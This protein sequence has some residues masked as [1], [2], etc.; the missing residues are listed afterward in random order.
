MGR[1]FVCE[2]C[3]DGR[4]IASFRVGPFD[5]DGMFL[6]APCAVEGGHVVPLFQVHALD[7]TID[8]AWA[9]VQKQKRLADSAFEQWRYEPI[10]RPSI[11]L[12]DPADHGIHMLPPI[13][14]RCGDLGHYAVDCLSR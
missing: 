6:C 4:T 8:V 7:A 14:Y 3:P 12:A 2:R 13:C 9:V 11:K 1:L 5:G 10:Q